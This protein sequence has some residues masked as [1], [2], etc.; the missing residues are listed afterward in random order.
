[1]SKMNLTAVDKDLVHWV[2]SKSGFFDTAT[3]TAA[4]LYGQFVEREGIVPAEEQRVLAPRLLTR[5]RSAVMTVC[6]R[7]VSRAVTCCFLVESAK[8]ISMYEVGV[9]VRGQP[10]T[11][12]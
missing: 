9:K 2:Y 5:C 3:G 7:G 1:M 11:R 8:S 10:V 6:H 12:G 4:H